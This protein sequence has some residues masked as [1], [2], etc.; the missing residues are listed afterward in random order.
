MVNF[1]SRLLCTRSRSPSPPPYDQ[2]S[3]DEKRS[4]FHTKSKYEVL[5]AY[6]PPA[7][8]ITHPTQIDAR[9]L[10]FLRATTTKT[11]S[12]SVP[13]RGDGDDGVLP[14]I[15]YRSVKAGDVDKMKYY[16]EYVA[17]GDTL[18]DK[19]AVTTLSR[20]DLCKAWVAAINACH[21]FRT[22]QAV[23]DEQEAVEQEKTPVGD[24]AAATT[25]SDAPKVKAKPWAEE[26]AKAGDEDLIPR[27]DHWHQTYHKFEK[28]V[29]IAL[30]NL[31]IWETTDHYPAPWLPCPTY[32]FPKHGKTLVWTFAERLR[33]EKEYTQMRST[34]VFSALS[35][36]SL[37]ETWAKEGRYE[38]LRK[39]AGLEW[40]DFEFYDFPEGFPKGDEL[41]GRL[42]KLA[43]AGGKK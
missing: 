9:A 13:K 42:W 19:P 29:R 37:D 17:A 34:F 6:T 31:H 32:D 23:Q 22:V 11:I 18:T 27:P 43:K 21:F 28:E 14:P 15:A 16:L 39:Q 35:I 8:A 40:R 4:F 2:S 41:R 10:L 36:L 20:L 12:S 3:V 30:A 26:M 7:R 1:F 38:E 24:G 5:P 25:Q 33:T